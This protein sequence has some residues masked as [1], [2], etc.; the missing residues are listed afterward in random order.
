MNTLAE[1]QRAMQRAI[2]TRQ[3]AGGLLRGLRGEP[4]MLRIYQHAYEVRLVAALRDNFGVLP[5]VMGDEAFDTLARA[6]VEAHPS[7]F[8][9]IRWFGD[10]LPAFMAAHEDLVP[11]PA[12]VDLAR[13]EW[14]LRGAFDA[15][16]GT[17]IDA[18]ALAAIAPE[19]WADLVFTAL[20]SVHLLPMHWAVEPVWRALQSVDEGEEPELPEPVE[21]AHALLV[22]RQGLENRWR[23]LEVAQADLLQAAL[24]GADFGRLCELAATQAGDDQAAQVAVQALQSWLA[25]GLLLGTRVAD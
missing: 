18:G 11:H 1:Q 3:D 22:W 17:P 13:M 4:P 20:P 2:T 19:Q 9:S 6:Y 10:E 16:D 14:A 25:D 8:P 12:L 21:H 23:S 7:Q 5:Q 15:A 24:D